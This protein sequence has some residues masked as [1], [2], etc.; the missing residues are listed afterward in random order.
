MPE[1]L[2]LRDAGQH[3]PGVSGDRH[4][5][6]WLRLLYRMIEQGADKSA[7][8]HAGSGDLC[9][10]TFLNTAVA[11]QETIISRLQLSRSLARLQAIADSQLLIK[12]F[13]VILYCV[14]RYNHFARDLLVTPA[15]SQQV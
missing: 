5:R 11:S 15:R 10:S 12:M 2:F 6:C 3:C 8:S 4:P 13:D 1:V 9:G 7:G 14:D